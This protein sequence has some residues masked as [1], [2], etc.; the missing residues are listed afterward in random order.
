MTVGLPHALG[1]TKLLKDEDLH[2]GALGIAPIYDS[3]RARAV[4]PG[5]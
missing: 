2:R 4:G 5:A 3:L 1:A